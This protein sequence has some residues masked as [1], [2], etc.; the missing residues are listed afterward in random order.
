MYAEEL[1]TRD[2]VRIQCK[3]CSEDR[4][5]SKDPCVSVDRKGDWV[6]WNCHHCGDKGAAPLTE[7]M[8]KTAVPRPSFAIDLS[9]GLTE[10][11]KEY[12][13]I[14]GLK[15]KV[16]YE[17]R[18][19]SCRRSFRGGEQPAIGF[20]NI[21][22]GKV[23][24]VKY[25]GLNKE[26]SQEAG[27]EQAL[28]GQDKII[29][30][31]LVI[32]EGEID[33][34]SA[35]QSGF[36]SAVSVPGGAPLRVSDGKISPSEDRKFSFIWEGK[37][38]LDK[39]EKIILAVDND[40][41]GQALQE[42]LARRIGKARCWTVTYPDGCKDLNDVLVR[43]GELDVR[44]VIDEARPFPINGLFD[45]ST[46]F[47]AIEDKYVNGNGKGVSTG[48]TSVDELYTIVPGQLSV[49]TGWP[50]S[51]K[52]NFVDQLCVNLAREKDWR[53]MMASFENPPEDHIIK[54][55]EIFLKKPFYP[56]PT[57]RMTQDE[58]KL[59]K[60]WVRDHFLFLD[61]A[62]GGTS[63]ESIL[64]RAQAAVARIGI[65]GMVIDPY[66]YIELP[67]TGTET[68]SI[69]HML[70]TVN[71]FAKANEVHTWFVAHPAKMQREGADLPIP[72]GMA[73]SGSM[74]W[75]AKADVGLTVHRQ[76]D[77]VLIKVWKCRWR[78]V[79]KLGR[80]L[81]NYDLPSGTYSAPPF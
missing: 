6:V 51:G 32:T 50:S 15:E 22:N 53:F 24:G 78:W 63:L 66:N 20:P 44:R 23:V 19:F 54:L 26:F 77:E 49:V 46:Y 34:I 3:S 8:P 80:A 29:A 43:H 76:T 65:R 47:D 10:E 16:C 59:A 69:N 45:A 60:E 27:S 52:S 35:R 58:L 72:D 30:P 13:S 11:A 28:W 67:R 36:E 61:V 5:N 62:N 41:P 38:F 74:S 31:I 64:Q 12:L 39:M 7:W 17:A 1:G 75:W 37:S 68:E 4:T 73:I 81:L 70:T 55:A 40:E 42:E 71:A 14:R 57:P 33:A 56:G 25:R 21:I 48:Y 79:G 9:V 2:H 18:L